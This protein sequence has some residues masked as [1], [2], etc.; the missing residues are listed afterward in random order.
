M[1]V[2]PCSLITV[3]PR[4]LTFPDCVFK[5][6]QKTKILP[7]VFSQ[8]SSPNVLAAPSFVYLLSPPVFCCWA[9]NMKWLSASLALAQQ[10]TD[11]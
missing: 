8:C 10:Y 5:F 11:S 3:P 2:G 4:L 1:G 9:A 7:S 6:S